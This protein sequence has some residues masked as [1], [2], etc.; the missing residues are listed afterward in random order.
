[1]NNFQKK[2]IFVDSLFVTLVTLTTLFKRLLCHADDASI[3]DS[4]PVQKIFS[5]HTIYYDIG[6]NDAETDVRCLE[7][8][9]WV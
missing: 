6:E 3:Q 7:I 2:F 4:A 5:L 1:M 8:F 9:I